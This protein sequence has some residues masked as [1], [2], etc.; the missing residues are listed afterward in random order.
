MFTSIEVDTKEFW[1]EPG[2]KPLADNSSSTAQP[3][4]RGKD[5]Y[6]SAPPIAEPSR[7]RAVPIKPTPEKPKAVWQYNPLHDVE[8]L[9]WL[10]KH[11]TLNRDT[12][13]V[14]A[15]Y[16]NVEVYAPE[17]GEPPQARCARLV[18]QARA[19]QTLRPGQY[20]RILNL[21]SPNVLSGNL[22]TLH[23]I[24]RYHDPDPDSR[25]VAEAL[26]EIR[27]SLVATYTS[28][29]QDPMKI[30]NCV[31]EDICGVMAKAFYQA[32]C[33]LQVMVNHIPCIRPLAPE[34]Y[35]LG[36][37]DG[38]IKDINERPAPVAKAQRG[39]SKRGSA[40]PTPSVSATGTTSTTAKRKRDEA[41]PEASKPD[42]HADPMDVDEDKCPSSPT[43]DAQAR[44]RR[45]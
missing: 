30:T 45:K 28:A 24:L 10:A 42:T 23:P 19:A 8:A 27:H 31:S 44:K 43:D 11:L 38:S 17:A 18:C 3:K 2:S 39:G 15:E 20:K 41:Q 13:F 33:S 25:S 16:P 26:E 36:K 29:E 4:V 37:Q 6:F 1:F 12:Y 9:S 34:L 5:K 14:L 22:A 35:N 21:T 7:L 32:A 40:K